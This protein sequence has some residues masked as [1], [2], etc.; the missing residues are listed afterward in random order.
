MVMGE[1][2]N[3]RYRITLLRPRFI[4]LVAVSPEEEY[5]VVA[6]VPFAAWWLF[7]GDDLA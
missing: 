2:A 4:L 7:A 6:S 5:Q 1:F 3:Q